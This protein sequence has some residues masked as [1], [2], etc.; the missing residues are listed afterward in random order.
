MG[1]H[2]K[3]IYWF[4]QPTCGAD[5]P[6]PSTD[7]GRPQN[8][9][10]LTGTAAVVARNITIRLP[11]AFPEAPNQTAQIKLLAKRSGVAA[12]TIRRILKGEVSPRLDNL[13]AIAQA[14]GISVSIL[15]SK[16][17]PLDK[18]QASFRA[19]VKQPA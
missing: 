7:M 9:V 18:F 11:G 17:G 2:D 1:T 12:E 4:A 8:P 3:P 10:Y 6:L 16:T 14:F 19:E 5:P 13:D 15:T